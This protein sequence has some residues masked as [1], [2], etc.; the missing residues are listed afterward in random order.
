ML[1]F[2]VVCTPLKDSYRRN[3][4]INVETATSVFFYNFYPFRAPL[5]IKISKLSA[6]LLR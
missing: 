3:F 6:L 4:I 1:I 5:K 2:F